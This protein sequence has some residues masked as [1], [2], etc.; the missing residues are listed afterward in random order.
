QIHLVD[1]AG[2]ERADATGASGL[3]LKE[4]GNINKSLVTL[5]NVISSLGKHSHYYYLLLHVVHGCFYLSAIDF[6]LGN[7][8]F[9]TRT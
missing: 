9:E 3:R 1:L 5:G 2:S 4:G 6:C 7:L 8:Y